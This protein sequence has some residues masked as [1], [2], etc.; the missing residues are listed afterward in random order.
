VR[1]IKRSE[2]A[3]DGSTTE[4]I[5]FSPDG[6]WFAA[7]HQRAA[8]D[9]VIR[10]W[11]VDTWEIAHDIIDA[12]P[13][14]CSAIG[15]T[16]DGK[17]LLRAADRNPSFPADSLVVYDTETWKPIWGIP[18]THFYPSVLAISP[19][20]K[21]VAIGGEVIIPITSPPSTPKPNFIN[22]IAIVDME[23]RSIVRTIPDTISFTFGQLAWSSDG[24]RLTGIGK[25]AWDGAANHGMGEYTG[26]PD[27]IMIFDPN[28]GKQL[29]G[30]EWGPIS[31]HSL[32][33]TPD[34]K[35]LI[36]GDRGNDDVGLGARI[37]DAQRRELLQTI[38]GS[39]GGLAVSRD[40]HYFAVGNKKKTTVWEFK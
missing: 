39:V 1:D 18:T 7:C 32:R 38:P 34:G 21:F 35:F 15:F 11:N 23:Q 30:D 22:N 25:R 29:A 37:W 4:L 14:G 27:N 9:V 6:R 20:G 16:P 10:I 19:D 8:N 31:W 26:G 40:G 33:Y 24:L 5:K 3:N 28:S 36:E 17:L 12:T 2:G 13:G